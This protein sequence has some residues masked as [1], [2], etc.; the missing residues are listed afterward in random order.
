[1]LA[2]PGVRL[3]KAMR[4]LHPQKFGSVKAIRVRMTLSAAPLAMFV[5]TGV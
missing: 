4:T 3:P 5:L 2:I 1:M